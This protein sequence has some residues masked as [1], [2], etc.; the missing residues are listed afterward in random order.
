MHARM[1][2]S[3]RARGATKSIALNEPSGLLKKS[4]LKKQATR[5]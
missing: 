4:K 1:L 2:G 3:R 5:T